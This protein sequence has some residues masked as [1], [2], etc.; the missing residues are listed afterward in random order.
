MKKSSRRKFLQTSLI[1]GA[2]G[3]FAAIAQAGSLHPLSQTPPETAGPFYPVLPQ[4]DKDFDLTRI[5]RQSSM[6]RGK[7]IWIETKVL[8]ITGK[9]IENASVEL[10]QANAAGKYRH[11][12]DPNPAPLDPNFQGW[13][14]VATGKKG[15]IR[16]KTIMPGEYPASKTWTRPPHIHFKISKRSYIELITQMYFPEQKLNETDLLLKRKNEE[17]QK[18]M[19]ASRGKEDPETYSYRIVMQR[20]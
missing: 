20:A 17:E 10:W 13:A 6:A 3:G 9:P 2:F 7:I 16:F 15:Q 8:D 12:H 18:L 19:I 5:E 14:I 4:K 1:S 11:P